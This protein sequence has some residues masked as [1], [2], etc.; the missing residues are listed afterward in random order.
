MADTQETIKALNY[1]IGTA[2]DGENGYREA[3]DEADSGDLKTRLLT[4]QPTARELSRQVGA[5]GD[6][7]GRRP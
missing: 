7:L 2:I 4:A 5:R 3:A 1:L 6:E